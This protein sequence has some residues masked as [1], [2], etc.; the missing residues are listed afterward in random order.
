M[1]HRCPSCPG[2]ESLFHY[3]YEAC[4]L[5]KVSDEALINYKQWVTTDRTTLQDCS[6]T[7]IEFIKAIIDKINTLTSHHFIAK[8]QSRFLSTQKANLA[9]DEAIIILDF[10]ENYSFVIQDAAQ[11]HHW[12]NSQATLHPFVLYCKTG[13]E[14]CHLSICIISDCLKHETITVHKFLETLLNHVKIKL[15][16]IKKLLYF[17]DGAASQYKNYKNFC[18]LVFHSKDFGL[19]AEWHFFATSLG[20]NACNRIGGTVKREAAKASLQATVSGHILTPQHLFEWASAHI[21]NVTFFFVSKE[22]VAEHAQNQDER[23]AN[24]KTIAGTR[25]YHS[26]IPLNESR[27]L[28]VQRVSGDN[29]A[30]L[31]ASVYPDLADP[32]SQIRLTLRECEV[33]KFVACLY[34][35]KWWIGYIRDTNEEHQDIQVVFMHPHGPARSFSWPEREDVCFVPLQCILCIVNPPSTTNGRSYYLDKKDK[36]Y[37]ARIT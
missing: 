27:K 23:F 14:V 21:K 25:S 12:D 7:V 19:D 1:L 30:S 26:F 24:A 36:D 9:A 15:P 17:S 6:K 37:I 5:D 11:G 2:S 35:G 22:K 20:K 10:A 13:D 32:T 31:E 16:H 33:G 4:K 18:N 28:R 8:H 29:E 3:L 34:D